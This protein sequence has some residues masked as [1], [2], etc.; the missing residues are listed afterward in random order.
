MASSGRAI[1]DGTLTLTRF[2]FLFWTCLRQ[3]I[4]L[5]ATTRVYKSDINSLSAAKKE[6]ENRLPDEISDP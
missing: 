1:D 6:N 2:I 5:A 4:E 3:L